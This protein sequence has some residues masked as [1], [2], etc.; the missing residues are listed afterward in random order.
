MTA[1]GHA[2]PGAESASH[3]HYEGTPADRLG[4]GEPSTPLWLP[5][6]GI[7][8]V[9]VTLLAYVATRPA[10][11][12]GAELALEAAPEA[13]SPSASVARPTGEP[14]PGFRRA[15]GMPSVF[16]PNGLA[17]PAQ[18][19]A[20]APPP[21]P[22]VSVAQKPFMRPAKSGP[23]AAPPPPPPPAAR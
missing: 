23:R 18:S 14:P 20:V 2:T 4:P 5:L 6:V 12:T 22:T 17:K 8:L 9:L 10:G 3:D 11:K 15:P 7:G 21:T 19:G 1:H 13:A 16:I